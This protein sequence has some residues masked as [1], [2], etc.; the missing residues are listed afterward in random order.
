MSDELLFE[1]LKF[2]ETKQFFHEHEI[3]KHLPKLTKSTFHKMVCHSGNVEKH[4]FFHK[5]YQSSDSNTG[6][7]R[8]FAAPT[9]CENFGNKLDEVFIRT[10]VSSK[11]LMELTKHRKRLIKINFKRFSPIL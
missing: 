11:M 6:I 2:A 4:V 7:S 1:S 3:L 10:E 5:F 8:I 9:D